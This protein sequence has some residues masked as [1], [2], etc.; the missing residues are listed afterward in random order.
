[1]KSLKG[2]FRSRSKSRGSSSSAGSI[3]NEFDEN[4]LSSLPLHRAVVKNE[5]EKLQKM[6]SKAAVPALLDVRDKSKRTPLLAACITEKWDFV[7]LLLEASCDA[8]APDKD[9]RTALMASLSR[10]TCTVSVVNSLI[11]HG[12]DLKK[13]DKA[14]RTSLH[15]LAASP[16]SAHEA[17]LSSF[18]STLGRET[19][20]TF[21]DLKDNDHMTAL[22]LAVMAGT[23]RTSN[24]DFALNVFV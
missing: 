3:A 11:L 22:H 18:L 19:G 2:L 13:Q 17:I 4:E 24:I 10:P 16:N 8:N 23:F 6:I 12:A 21:M 20:R 1:M 7:T 5:K 9:G 15:Y 14:G